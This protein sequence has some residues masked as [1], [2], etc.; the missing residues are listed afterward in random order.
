[1]ADSNS[2]PKR[3]KLRGEMRGM[4]IIQLGHGS[5]IRTVRMIMQFK[6]HISKSYC[7][8]GIR[9]EATNS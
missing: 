9:S 1:M 3:V 5:K 7:K 2:K 8:Q 4:Q 6:E